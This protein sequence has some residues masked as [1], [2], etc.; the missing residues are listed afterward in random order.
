MPAPLARPA[1]RVL[2]RPRHRFAAACAALVFLIALGAA[3]LLTLRPPTPLTAQAPPGEF[4]AARAYAH[5]EV[6]AART[7]PAGSAANDEVRSHLERELRALGLEVQTQETVGA[8]AGHLSG[9]AAGATL[10]QVRNV[11]ARAGCRVRDRRQR[12]GGGA[13]AAGA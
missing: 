10:A 7:H 13:H 4:S 9:A 1:E 6:V 8:E 12:L 2:I 11:V 5:A 3:T